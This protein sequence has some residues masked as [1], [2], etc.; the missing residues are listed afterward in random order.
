MDESLETVYLI[1]AV[2]KSTCIMQFPLSSATCTS[3]LNLLLVIVT[4]ASASNYLLFKTFQEKQRL[5]AMMMMTTMM[6][7]KSHRWM[8]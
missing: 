4:I 5:R 2:T 7:V 1:C 3:F 6:T 8:K